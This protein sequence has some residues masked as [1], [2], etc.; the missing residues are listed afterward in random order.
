PA[1]T[2]GTRTD[3]A[4]AE[5]TVYA[6][7]YHPIGDARSVRGASF[8][9][10]AQH[11]AVPVVVGKEDSTSMSSSKSE[12]AGAAPPPQ[13]QPQGTWRI[14]SAFEALNPFARSRQRPPPEVSAMTV[15]RL[16]PSSRR[17]EPAEGGGRW[18]WNV[19]GKIED[20]ASKKVGQVREIRGGG[21]GEKLPVMRIPA[22]PTRRAVREEVEGPEGEPEAQSMWPLPAPSPLPPDPASL[23]PDA[24]LRPPTAPPSPIQRV[25]EAHEV[26]V[27]RNVS[28]GGG[29]I[30][31]AATTMGDRSA[32]TGDISSTTRS[33]SGGT[34]GTG[35]LPVLRIPA[36]PLRG[37]E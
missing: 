35:G 22:P 36:P 37:R 8:D 30:R 21:G 31:S 29:T 2:P 20:F 6:I 23:N 16:P 5:S 17:H 32:T 4:S 1:A 34:G 26:A 13:Q 25:R 33:G 18:D 10:E 11:E 14:W 24:D 9:V 15:R 7:R 3:T 12:G 28:I 27:A 19:L